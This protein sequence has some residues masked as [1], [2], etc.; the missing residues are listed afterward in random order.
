MNNEISL[1]ELR[2]V[3]GRWDALCRQRPLCQHRP[4]G[5]AVACGL[6]AEVECDNG[7]QS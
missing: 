4:P 1:D 7:G 3:C 6:P 5:S 2:W